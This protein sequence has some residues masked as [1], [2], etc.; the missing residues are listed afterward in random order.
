[1]TFVFVPSSFLPRMVDGQKI[2]PQDYEQSLK[3]LMTICMLC[4]DSGLAYN[5]VCVFRMAIRK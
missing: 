2:N 4:N 3:E 1:M 5:E